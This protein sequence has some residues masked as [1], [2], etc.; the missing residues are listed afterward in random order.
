MTLL[1]LLYAAGALYTLWQLARGWRGLLAERPTPE[2]RNLA[3]LVAFLLLTPPAVYLHELG[4]ALAVRLVGGQVREIGYFLYW[5]YTA[6]SGRLTP[7]QQWLVAAAGPLVSLLLGWGA[8][9]LGL[10]WRLRPALNQV[11]LL[12]GLIQLLQILLFYPLLTLANLGDLLGSDFAVLYSPRTPVLAAVAGVVHLDSLGMLFLGLRLPAVRRRYEQQIG[13]EPLAEVPP[14]PGEQT[15]YAR[16]FTGAPVPEPDPEAPPPDQTAIISAACQL[17]SDASPAARQQADAAFS[18]D[19]FGVALRQTLEAVLAAGRGQRA[20]T[21]YHQARALLRETE[22]V[23]SARYALALLGLF[24]VPRDRELFERFATVPVFTRVATGG[25]ASIVGS[26][27]TAGEQ[28]LPRLH[29]LARVE[30]VELLAAS[31]PSLPL[32]RRLV[33]E[34]LEPGYE[35][36]LALA[37]AREARLAEILAE[38]PVDAT[39]VDRAGVLLATLAT[40]AVHGGPAGTLNDYAEAGLALT[41]YLAATADRWDL[42]QLVRLAAFAAFLREATRLSTAE[43]EQ[44]LA[45]VD[46]RL[47]DPRWQGVVEAALATASTAEQRAAALAAARAIGRS[48][49]E[50]V[51]RWLPLVGD[52]ELSTLFAALDP[53]G[54]GE[55]AARFAAAAVARVQPAGEATPPACELALNVALEALARAPAAALPLVRLALQGTVRNRSKALAVLASWPAEARALVQAEVRTLAEHDPA[56]SVR[57][58]ARDLLAS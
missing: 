22:A 35:E 2:A 21:L 26:L 33:R 43:R 46:R 47:A 50:E 16:V 4:H 19:Y 9:G 28:L 20:A 55:E 5:G 10:S 1:S 6:Y 53:P 49:R 36:Q 7:E 37:I 39:L 31:S 54:T 44:L 57:L 29:G 12:F 17:L 41:R 15:V 51:Y 56:P 34:G 3:G 11:L 25:L 40:T 48:P 30:L 24:G 18:R 27:E 32:A 14:A 58:R 52:D 8:L 13:S 38:Q 42:P 45:E 23:G